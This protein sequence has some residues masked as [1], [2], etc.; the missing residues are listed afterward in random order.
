MTHIVA[1]LMKEMNIGVRYR[2]ND[3]QDSL[4]AGKTWSVLLVLAILLFLEGDSNELI[5]STRSGG[6]FSLL[7]WPS[8]AVSDSLTRF[9]LGVLSGV[10]RT[11]ALRLDDDLDGVDG[12]ATTSGDDWRFPRTELRVCIVAASRMLTNDY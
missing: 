9:A 3:L 4:R 2:L 5:A 6:I 7:L 11:L 8:W 12:D 10:G 1:T